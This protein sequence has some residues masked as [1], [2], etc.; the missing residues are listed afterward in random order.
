VWRIKKH[1]KWL[2][3]IPSGKEIILY[4]SLKEF[5]ISNVWLLL[6][7]N[8]SLCSERNYCNLYCLNH[9][10]YQP[11]IFEVNT[12][13]SIS[14]DI[15]YHWCD[16]RKPSFFPKRF[17]NS[18]P[19]FDASSSPYA[20][21]KTFWRQSFLVVKSGLFSLHHF[22]APLSHNKKYLLLVKRACLFFTKNPSI[23]LKVRLLF[24]FT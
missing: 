24:V 17:S 20:S 18:Y 23:S 13:I 3:S 4:K 6:V 10:K 5:V 14:C 2:V 22:L 9:N 8:Q 1:P 7:G 21:V 19:S 12:T 15:S 11:K 16:I